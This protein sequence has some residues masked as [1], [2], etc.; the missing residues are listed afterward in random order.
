[1]T[2]SAI[3]ENEYSYSTPYLHI[4]DISFTVSAEWWIKEFHGTI[5]SEHITPKGKAYLVDMIECYQIFE[6]EGD[7]IIRVYPIW[8]PI[9]AH[10]Q[11]DWRKTQPLARR[12]ARYDSSVAGGSS[13]R[14]DDNPIN[15]RDWMIRY[16]NECIKDEITA[17]R[18]LQAN[19][20]AQ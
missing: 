11:P 18:A 4:S 16:W 13:Y 1:M 9:Y 3:Q 20:I 5:I 17:L 8:Y 15:D 19:R 7:R 12:I 2:F 6:T 14:W 10:I